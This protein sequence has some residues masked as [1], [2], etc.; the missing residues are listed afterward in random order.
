MAS[1]VTEKDLRVGRIYPR[2]QEIR[3]ISVQIAVAVAE[4]AYEVVNNL[5]FF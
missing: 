5:I 4:Y 2:L 3:E 1:C